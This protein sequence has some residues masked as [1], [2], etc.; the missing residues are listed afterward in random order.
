MLQEVINNGKVIKYSDKFYELTPSADLLTTKV[1]LSN[2]CAM[3][4]A[5][6]NMSMCDVICPYCT[7]GS[8][9][10]PVRSMKI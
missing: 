8:V 3:C 5:E 9:F 10:R 1:N 6:A 4:V 2:A 7:L